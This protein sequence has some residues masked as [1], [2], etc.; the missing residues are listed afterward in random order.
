MRRVEGLK[1]LGA[2][3]GVTGVVEHV[4]AD[5][6]SLGPKNFGPGHRRGQKIGV[7]EGDI[8]GGMP[9]GSLRRGQARPKSVR[10]EPPISP[11]S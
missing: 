4:G 7:A 8:S 11:S 6:Y 2:A 3:V 5:E 1:I 10:L 9:G